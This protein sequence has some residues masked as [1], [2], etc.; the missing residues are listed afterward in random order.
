[1]ETR[2]IS[3]IKSVFFISEKKEF[4]LKILR[5]VDM[6]EIV[7]IKP[8]QEKKVD[9]QAFQ[10][11]NENTYSDLALYFH[12]NA[13]SEYLFNR[14]NNE[15]TLMASPIKFDELADGEPLNFEDDFKQTIKKVYSIKVETANLKDIF[16]SIAF[17]T[18]KVIGFEFWFY[19]YKETSIELIKCPKMTFALTVLNG[20]V[21][22]QIGQQTI[23][24]DVQNKQCGYKS[25]I[26][27]HI[28]LILL[29]NDKIEMYFNSKMIFTSKIGIDFTK[30]KTDKPCFLPIFDGETTEIKVWKSQ[31]DEKYLSTNFKLPHPKIFDEEKH[32]KLIL[33]SNKLKTKSQKSLS[34]TGNHPNNTSFDSTVKTEH[35]KTLVIT[36]P[37]DSKISTSNLQESNVPFQHSSET[38]LVTQIQKGTP[39]KVSSSMIG[40]YSSQSTKKVSDKQFFPSP[41]VAQKRSLTPT[42]NSESKIEDKSQ[43]PSPSAIFLGYFRLQELEITELN[44]TNIDNAIS[45]KDI[46]KFQSL[47]HLNLLNLIFNDHFDKGFSFSNR[48]AEII[49][50]NK[51]E[52]FY[53]FFNQISKS[54]VFFA[55][56]REIQILLVKEMNI[57]KLFILL[58]LISF[59]RISELITI[60]V[61]VR[62]LFWYYNEGCFDMS[63]SIIDKIDNVVLK[64]SGLL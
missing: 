51:I 14:V 1:M 3:Y 20:C 61:Q 59:L 6:R 16:S 41:M 43:K 8:I 52:G 58:S 55:F 46:S 21:T 29:N 64:A 63:R 47:F 18:M 54:K 27:N 26:W 13:E 45:K 10:E 38:S 23:F 49:F 12:F 53:R 32:M 5:P 9:N 11:Q 60:I 57:E 62:A 7:G 2:H 19:S 35:K 25:K 42:N 15:K 33:K 4:L 44:S 17:E 34:L 22:I 30:L 40:A 28:C 50:T 31:I 24:T 36:G 56:F 37:K 48:C 39:G